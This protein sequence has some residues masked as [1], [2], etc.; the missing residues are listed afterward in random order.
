MRLQ[1]GSNQCSSGQCYFWD[2]LRP[3]INCSGGNNYYQHNIG[4]PKSTDYG[5]QVTST[6][7]RKDSTDFTVSVGVSGQSNPTTGLSVSN[8]MQPI[9]IEIGAEVQ[10]TT[11]AQ[12]P[13]TDFIYNAGRSTINSNYYYFTQD[14]Q[15]VVIP[16]FK[17]QWARRP[18]LYFN[19]GAWRVSFG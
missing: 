6:I 2:D 13:Q 11:G 5:Q 9:V 16:P 1:T 7:D 14:G 18:S 15:D 17:G 3:C 19:G 12:V 10:G 4:N 8:V